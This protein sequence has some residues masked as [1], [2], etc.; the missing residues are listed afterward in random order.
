[1]LP[2]NIMTSQMVCSDASRPLSDECWNNAERKSASKA[3]KNVAGPG[4]AM[5]LLPLPSGSIGGTSRV[6][7][8]TQQSVTGDATLYLQLGTNVWTVIFAKLTD[9]VFSAH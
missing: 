3:R 9:D 8:Y 4:L 2:P 5:S 6:F 1:M 7:I